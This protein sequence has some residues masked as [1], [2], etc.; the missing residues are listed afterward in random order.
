MA[1]VN[2]LA[3]HILKWEELPEVNSERWLS[4]VN[5]EGEV[6]EFIPNYEGVYKISNYGR[7]K[8]LK[9]NGI[10]HD[11][12]VKIFTYPDGRYHHARLRNGK[13]THS[14]VHRLVA[15]TFVYKESGKNCVDH[16]NGN[17]H[18]NRACNLKWV[19]HLENSN[20]PVTVRRKEEWGL[21]MRNNK[22]S[23]PVIQCDKDWNEIAIYESIREAQRKTGINKNDISRAIRNYTYT[24]KNGDTKVR[25]SAGGYKWKF[26]I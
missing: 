18:D 24:Y 26:A 8:S 19:T 10:P 13:I 14:S 5:L 11:K 6:W 7:L 20:N 12:I 23:K 3:P 15:K 22:R 2:R 4:L 1:D 21:S 9:R 16:I 25:K 17:T